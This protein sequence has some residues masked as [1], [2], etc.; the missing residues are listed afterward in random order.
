MDVS[1]VEF[2]AF[3][4]KVVQIAKDEILRD[5]QNELS[6]NPESGDLI[7]GSGGLR[8]ARFKLEGRGRREGA[9]AIYLWLPKARPSF[10]SHYTPRQNK[11]IFPQ[12]PSK[13]SGELLRPSKPVT[14]HEK[15]QKRDSVS[16][17]RTRSRECR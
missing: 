16:L 11:P 13:F 1:F 2:E 14:T 17:R 7:P 6:A 10:F 8:K 15:D 4:E 3:T 5:F 12:L 9:R